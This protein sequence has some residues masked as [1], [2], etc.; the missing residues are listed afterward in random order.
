MCERIKNQIV[1]LTTWLRYT[2]HSMRHPSQ[3]PAINYPTL[4]KSYAPAE[5]QA[6]I[7]IINTLWHARL[8]RALDE[9]ASRKEIE[10]PYN[11]EEIA[12]L[13]EY[14]LPLTCTPEGLP[15]YGT[16]VTIMSKNTDKL[17]ITVQLL[18]NGD[19]DILDI[20]ART[21]VKKSS[22]LLLTQK[23]LSENRYHYSARFISL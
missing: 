22:T 12:D 17:P 8:T 18:K 9:A 14:F 2:A 3:N 5:A 15:W 1:N 19:E 4:G 20:N 16:L 21:G 23:S 6:K 10:N 11:E 7:E 13:F